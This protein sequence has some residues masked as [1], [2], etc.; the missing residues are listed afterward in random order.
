MGRRSFLVL[1]RF[2][3]CSG[4]RI[5][6]GIFISLSDGVYQSFQDVLLFEPSYSLFM[7]LRPLVWAS[8]L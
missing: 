8:E 4:T 1:Q 2:G 3:D 7:V 6:T 5:L